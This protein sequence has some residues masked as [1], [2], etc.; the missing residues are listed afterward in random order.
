MLRDKKKC[1]SPN[2]FL[3]YL[4]FRG[5]EGRLIKSKAGRQEIDNWGKIKGGE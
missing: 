1:L 2:L 3:H 4:M 5:R